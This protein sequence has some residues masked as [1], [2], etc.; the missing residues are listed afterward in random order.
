MAKTDITTSVSFGNNDDEHLPITKCICGKEFGLWD[1]SIS[2]YED[3][4]TPC[5]GC[6]RKLIFANEIKVYEVH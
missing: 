4:P 6:G 1:L 5:P 2:I 3:E